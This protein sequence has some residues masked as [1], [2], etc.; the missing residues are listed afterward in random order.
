MFQSVYR[1]I[2]MYMY[3]YMY[4]KSTHSHNSRSGVTRHMSDNWPTT[5][6]WLRGK[7]RTQQLVTKQKA[8]LKRVTIGAVT[9]RSWK[10][11]AHC[12]PTCR[13]MLKCCG[14]HVMCRF[15]QYVGWFD[16]KGVCSVFCL[17]YNFRYYPYYLLQSAPWS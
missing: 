2:H 10:R 12:K 9:Y 16:I 4:L 3:M 5:G 8:Y 6:V 11:G 14:I 13:S 17:M 7:S 15:V 1:C